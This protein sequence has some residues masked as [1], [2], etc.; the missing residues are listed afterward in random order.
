MVR[1]GMFSFSL[2]AIDS[3]F[4]RTGAPGHDKGRGSPRPFLSQQ[5]SVNLLYPEQF[6]G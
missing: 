4:P 5:V 2:R 1:L 6:N 3:P